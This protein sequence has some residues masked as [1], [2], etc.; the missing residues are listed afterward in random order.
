MGSIVCSSR[1]KNK[2]LCDNRAFGMHRPESLGLSVSCAAKELFH[3]LSNK[4]CQKM[5]MGICSN[6]I[7]IET[8]ILYM[9][10]DVCFVTTG[11]DIT[12]LLGSTG[13]N[14]TRLVEKLKHATTLSTSTF[15]LLD[16]RILDI[17]AA[18]VIYYLDSSFYDDWRKLEVDET[19]VYLS[20]NDT[21]AQTTI[22]ELL[23]NSS[24]SVEMFEA[25]ASN[26]PIK[27]VIGAFITDLPSQGKSNDECSIQCLNQARAIDRICNSTVKSTFSNCDPM[28]WPRLVELFREHSWLCVFMVALETMPISLTVSVYRD[29]PLL[30]PLVYV[31]EHFESLCRCKRDNLHGMSVTFMQSRVTSQLPRQQLILQKLDSDIKA[32]S[33]SV[34]TLT[35]FCGLYGVFENVVAVKVIMG[36]DG[37]PAY[38]VTLQKQARNAAEIELYTKAFKSALE[39]ML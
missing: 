37:K 22:P 31:N 39:M 24:I 32:G 18:L 25:E 34:Q 23:A 20:E 30:Y 8:F 38:I 3:A 13:I 19:M 16:W 33:V 36:A 11:I 26:S 15:S 1:K 29:R 4:Y 27:D 7:A 35:C 17:V 21:R 14:I 10:S 28:E 9:H 6:S 5:L 12:M 2:V